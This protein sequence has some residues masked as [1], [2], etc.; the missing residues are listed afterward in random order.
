MAG[1]LQATRRRP[2]EVLAPDGWFRT[3]DL[4][5]VDADGFLHITGRN[6]NVIVA[7]QR[8]ATSTP[9][10]SRSLI[11][12]SPYVL[13]CVVYGRM[14]GGTAT[15]EHRP[16]PSSPTPRSSIATPCTPRD[17]LSAGLRSADGWTA[18]VRDAQ[19]AAAGLQA[20]SAT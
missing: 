19:P 12:G 8:Q 7:A 6:K 13:E 11:G 18:E 9:R 10:R 3:G 1:L 5:F 17:G 20:A 15:I 16:W 2:R 4:G 14:A